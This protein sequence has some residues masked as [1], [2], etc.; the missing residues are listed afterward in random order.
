MQFER[1]KYP[2]VTW[3][4]DMLAQIDIACSLRALTKQRESEADRVGLCPHGY[5]LCFYCWRDAGFPGG[6]R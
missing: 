3:A 4:P 6:A 2:S 5:L 1:L